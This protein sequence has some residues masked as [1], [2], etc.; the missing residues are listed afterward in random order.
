MRIRPAGSGDLAEV[1]RTEIAS[2]ATPWSPH[3]FLSLL[4]R[5]TVLFRIAESEDGEMLGHGILWWVLDEGEL[6]NLAVRPEAR[7][8]GIGRRL[9][10]VLLAEAALRGVERVF[11]EV[12]ESNGVAIELY[13]ERGFDQVGIRRKYYS[14]PVEDALVLQLDFPA[15]SP[16]SSSE[17]QRELMTDGP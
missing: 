12:R 15:P 7:G 13:R 17:P 10:D 1:V 6:A 9:L 5:E 3:T 4:D 16:S 14:S 11:L 2:F 8:R